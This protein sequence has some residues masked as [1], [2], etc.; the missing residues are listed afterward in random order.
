M[1]QV[2]QGRI[3]PSWV[4]FTG[5]HR[6]LQ[7]PEVTHLPQVNAGAQE[8]LSCAVGEGQVLH[9]EAPQLALVFGRPRQ[10]EARPCQ[11]ARWGVRAPT[12]IRDMA[13]PQSWPDAV[14]RDS[15]RALPHTPSLCW[16]LG[17]LA[18]SVPAHTGSEGR[19]STTHLL[20][21]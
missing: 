6:P 13:W 5:Q 20:G 19:Q 9:Q 4:P 12:S 15:G 18:L 16:V 2:E 14:M 17:K 7:S 8:Q 21:C 3:N 11:G 1:C 10:C